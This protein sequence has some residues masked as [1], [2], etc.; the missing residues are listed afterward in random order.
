MA[1][2]EVAQG[3]DSTSSVEAARPGREIEVPP[4]DFLSAEHES[5]TASPPDV[6]APFIDLSASQLRDGRVELQQWQA[7]G[8]AEKLQTALAQTDPETAA[9]PEGQAATA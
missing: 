5:Q 8:G 7:D 2:T 3:P 9:T 6:I 1:P 4:P